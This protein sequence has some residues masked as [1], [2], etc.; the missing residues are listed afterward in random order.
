[1]R[2]DARTRA[3]EPPRSSLLPDL[4]A[5]RSAPP[6]CE[7]CL[8]GVPAGQGGV[9]GA[10]NG[11]MVRVWVAVV[12]VKS[13]TQ[14]KSRLRGALPGVSHDRLVLGLLRDTITAV[15]DCPVVD[16]LIVVT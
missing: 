16:E 15:L 3:L 4:P 12:P 9:P 7:S 5:R 1:M 2:T 11:R 10:H 8:A 14:A 6:Q 13:F